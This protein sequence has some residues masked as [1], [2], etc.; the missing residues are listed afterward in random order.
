MNQENNDYMIRYRNE[1]VKIVNKVEDANILSQIY[2]YANTL[3]K[4]KRG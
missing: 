3:T 4:M 1:I 2:T